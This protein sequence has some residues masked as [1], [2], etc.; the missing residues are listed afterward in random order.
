MPAVERAEVWD[1]IEQ[2][3]ASAADSSTDARSAAV[4]AALTQLPPPELVSFDEHLAQLSA[5]AYSWELWGAAYTMCGGCSDDS[6]MD[7]RAWLVLQ[8]RATYEAALADPDSLAD[9]VLP[10]GDVPAA[11]ELLYAADVAHEAATG[12]PMEREPVGLPDLPEESWDFDDESEMA[13][14]YP[15]LVA[16]YWDDPL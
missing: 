15:R 11:E 13:A 16:R 7:F 1:L 5:A 3:A 14:R 8:G 10:D 4:T 6:F 2:A 9:V 12:S